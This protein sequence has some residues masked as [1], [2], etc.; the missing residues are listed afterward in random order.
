ML[1]L[2]ERVWREAGVVARQSRLGLYLQVEMVLLIARQNVSQM[3]AGDLYGVSQ[4][5]VSRTWRRLLPVID[6]IL[7]GCEQGLCDSMRA[8]HTVLVD[9]TF[10]RTGNRPASGCD[11]V[12]YSGYRGVQCLSIQVATDLSGR[13][14][15]VSS[16]APGS[17]HDSKAIGLAG[18]KDKL[19]D[20]RWI[21]DT[22]YTGSGAITPIK[23][24]PERD[25]LGWEYEFNAT[26]SRLRSPVEHAIAHLKN[27]KILAT[28]YRGPLDRLPLI[29]R[30]VSKLELYRLWN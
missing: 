19:H 23:R 14:L 8:G 21:A 15:A 6:R 20:G 5:T 29:I 27:W 18:W 13:L 26:V 28:G 10:I 22:A 9:G 30:A 17:R 24:N 12:N 4:P 1:D 3:V 11:R 2:V 16:P 25:R 7:P